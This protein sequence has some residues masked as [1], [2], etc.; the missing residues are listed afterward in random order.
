MI[1][2]SRIIR[3]SFFIS[4]GFMVFHLSG[5]DA[6]AGKLRAF[7]ERATREKS[8]RSSRAYQPGDEALGSLLG[9]MLGV[10]LASTI[11]DSFSYTLNR[12][13]PYSDSELAAWEL[14][15][16]GDPDLPFVRFDLNYQRVRSN[17]YGWDGRLEGGYGP[18]ALSARHTRYREKDPGDRLYI[19]NIH[20]LYRISFSPSVELGLGMGAIIMRGEEQHSG[21]SVTYPLNVY[22]IRYLGLR[23]VPTWSWIAGNTISDYDLAAS[24][25][26]RYCSLRIGY[27]WLL[28]G[29]E[30]IDGPYF[31]VSV[32]Y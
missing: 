31:G 27:R 9:T 21:F 5:G 15:K 19:T 29:G 12:V 16:K 22:P 30:T 11:G 1:T 7:E 18:F 3:F 13:R 14:R 26:Y 17:I 24:F 8:G 32:Y 25:V 23:F 6:R 28:V 20:S 4:T 10:A 2:K